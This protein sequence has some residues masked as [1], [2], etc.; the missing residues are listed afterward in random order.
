M[1]LF[2]LLASMT[3]SNASL[4]I[5]FADESRSF[6]VESIVNRLDGEARFVNGTADG[7]GPHLFELVFS[8]TDA[9]GGVK[10]A[11]VRDR[12]DCR[13][14]KL[15]VDDGSAVIELG[16]YDLPGEADAVDV[17][18]TVT[19]PVGENY[20]EWR[21][22][23]ANRSVKW[24]LDKTVYPCLRRI[25]KPGEADV[26]LPHA[27]LGARLMKKF[28]GNA[29]NLACAWG[30]YEYPSYFP[31]MTAYMIN[32]AGLAVYQD[33]PDARIK[34]LWAN[35]LDCWFET[36]V[37]N[38]G[39][40]GKA[41]EGPGYVVRTE[42]FRGDW[43]KAAAIYRRWALKQKWCA[44]GRISE[45]ADYPKAMS[46]PS[47]W[48][49]HYW[50]GAKGFTNFFARI[51]REA[52]DVKLGVRWYDW[53]TPGFGVYPEAFPAKEGVDA[54]GRGVTDLGYALMP[55]LNARIW[56]S[57]LLS[58]DYAKKDMCLKPDGTP[59]VEQWGSKEA[60]GIHRRRDYGIMCPG[61]KDWQ[62]LLL[63]LSERA[64]EE[65]H[66][67]ALYY[68]QLGCAAPRGCRNPAH[69]HPL[70]GGRWWADGNR[71]IMRRAHALLSPKGFA[72][73]TEGTA[74]CYMDDCDGFLAV[75]VPT[76]EDVPFYMAVYSGYTVY[77]GSRTPT[78]IEPKKAYPLMARE[79]VWGYANGSS[80]DWRGKNVPDANCDAMIQFARARQK[81]ADYLVYGSIL[82]DIKTLDP[83]PTVTFTAWQDLHSRKHP[84]D[85]TMPAVIGA[86]W[87]DTAE[88]T[89][90][91]L[92]VNVS[93][94]EQT[95]RFAV[96]DG[97]VATGDA[98]VADGICADTI[99]PRTIRAVVFRG[100]FKTSA[101]K[102]AH[103]REMRETREICSFL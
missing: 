4:E 8:Q 42:V 28:D 41:A 6:A 95:I 46:E 70:G 37:E 29:R 103:F 100:N 77:F 86:W 26:L 22:K 96:P 39:V 55:Y 84:V 45:R 97:L 50:W 40:V 20:A 58:Y 32:G 38:A 5:R 59:F 73:T 49:C 30:E 80:D 65:T 82:G 74:E 10:R 83:L 93:E 63:R 47:F 60:K 23:V 25:A 14:K 34:K 11:Y 24:G 66:A 7:K 90:A 85:G 19:L 31:M 92:A 53:S 64:L 54:A 3:L 27:G 2:F 35:N 69:G 21:L 48:I 78:R 76:P 68:D 1:T 101:C 62:D 17:T 102:W 56:D 71:E 18:A 94:A 98:K 33:D 43:W 13:R 51:K 87:R 44:K 9:T 15:T 88:K 89:V 81:Y 52:P 12:N 57:M 36:P 61:Q 79:F 99:A 72:V 16:G 91:L 75:T 67:T